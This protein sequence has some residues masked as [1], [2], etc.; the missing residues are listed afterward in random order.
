MSKVR[1]LLASTIALALSV[2]SSG[3]VAQAAV[4]PSLVIANTGASLVGSAISDFD[5]TSTL[6]LELKT[7][8]GEITVVVGDSGAIVAP[9]TSPKGSTVVLIGT[10]AQI[11][12][13]L[14]T[15]TVSKSCLATRT[16]TGKVT[17]GPDV[18]VFNPAN[19]HWYTSVT[20]TSGSWDE[21]KLAAAAKT[22]PNT[23]G[24]GY[25]ATI[26]SAEENTFVNDSFSNTALLGG[27]DATTE[28]EWYWMD[29]PEAGTKFF[30]NGAAVDG[31]FSKFGQDE[32][33][34]SG[35]VEDYLHLWGGDTWNDITGNSSSIVEF[36]GMPGDDF[37]G[38][39]QATANATSSITV[40]VLFEGDG[41]LSYPYL[42]T[43]ET[44]FAGM[45]PCSGVGVRFQQTQD[46]V[47]S[48][49]FVGE[50]SFSGHYDGNGKKLD[51]SS[52]SQ[53]R[54][55][56]FGNISGTSSATETSVKNLDVIGSQNS[57]SIGAGRS[58]LAQSISFATLDHV[59]LTGAKVSS[60]Y[61]VGLLATFISN[62]VVKNSSVT[63]EMTEVRFVFGLGGL[64]SYAESTQFISNE[65]NVTFGVSQ[66]G[67]WLDFVESMG[68]CVG[69][70]NNS[71]YTD[72]HST[73][74]INLTDEM[75]RPIMMVRSIGGLIGE[76]YQD[77][78]TDSSSSISIT[79]SR[80][81]GVGGLIGISNLSTIN[82]SF[83]TGTLADSNGSQIGGLIGYSAASTISNV[84]ATGAVS[85]D[86]MVGSLIGNMQAGS[87]V[88]KAYSTGLVTITN[89]TMS[90]GLIGYTEG[91]NIVDSYWKILSTGV[92]S[93]IESFGQE[94]P[95]HSGD[96]KKLSTFANWNISA[97]PTSSHDWAICPGAN[98]GYPYLAWQQP[99][100]ACSRAFTA[101]AAVTMNG[102]AYVGG[103]MGANATN[104]DPLATMSYQWFEGATPILGA[105][106]QYFK[107]N[108]ALKGKSISLRVTGAKD[109][110]MSMEV[111]S[112][113]V[114]V[115]GAPL[116]GTVVIGGFAANSG[117][118]TPATKAAVAKAMKGLGIAL[119]IKC[120]GF[121]S[122]KKLTAA[123]KKLATTR[124]A[125]VCA[126]LKVTQTSSTT[127][128]AAS[129][130]KK[131]DKLAEGVRVT[132][133]S[134]KR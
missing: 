100:N 57:N 56:I 111:T 77:S 74:S 84:Y 11:N 75:M 133:T 32:P 102:V 70:S 85:G 30:S 118:L 68:G 49:T 88:S 93:T 6:R 40:P 47:F 65:C 98:G 119:S 19:G 89:A 76:S 61:D 22:L 36:G 108:L 54:S 21:A 17:V 127:A 12:A 39:A 28:G 117:K 58:V 95:K 45:A 73:G 107:P 24:R 87:K 5:P 62:S 60:S 43:N 41:T 79:T 101:G 99:A 64:A 92:P 72:V 20:S 13:A 105:T 66:N 81:E 91:T 8:T 55:P 29:G 48:N 115:A 46:I 86:Y 67:R 126:A 110:Y 80:G 63:G 27:S 23:T 94:V 34:N 25:L 113:S 121:A 33:N 1:L 78:I 7:N 82:R 124:A 42:V 96:L 97:T 26:T 18:L 116:T 71:S 122:A 14:A 130:A 128:T 59:Q 123:Q 2:F 50:V 131:L 38:L 125:A 69:R 35:G 16:I 9:F 106:T 10:Q 53:L 112:A 132:V 90:R 4:A 83:A 103:S 109:G 37:S 120:E 3:F 129:V 104:W 15:T 52:A 44:D 31:V 134:V 114:V 51:A